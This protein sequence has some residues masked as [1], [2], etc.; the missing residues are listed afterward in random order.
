MIISVNLSRDNIDYVDE[1]AK[2]VGTSRYAILKAVLAK[3]VKKL[4][5]KYG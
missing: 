2:R 5:E 4:K 1:L 3:E